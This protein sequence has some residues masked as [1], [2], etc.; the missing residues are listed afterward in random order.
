MKGGF[1]GKM[2]FVDLTDRTVRE[3]ALAPGDIRRYIG[4]A[5]LN[6]RLA[7]DLIPAKADPLAPENAFIIGAGHLVG[8]SAP[9]AIKTIATTKG[10]LGG[11]I[12]SSAT[13]HF[14]HGM[15]AAGYDHL[16]IQGKASKPVYLKIF[17][18]G[19]EIAPARHLWGRDVYETT[20]RSL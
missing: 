10:P 14:G 20:G 1:A 9:G 4:G 18:D 13:G 8:T 19:V 11:T 3:E 6:A 17:R 16:V 12:V 2:L 5:R 7:Y 15:K